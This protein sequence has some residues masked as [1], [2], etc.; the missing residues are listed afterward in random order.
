MINRPS[1]LKQPLFQHIYLLADELS[2]ANHRFIQNKTAAKSHDSH[3]CKPMQ[4]YRV[5]P[6]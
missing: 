1:K 4:P 2:Q 3:L 6:N 5:D